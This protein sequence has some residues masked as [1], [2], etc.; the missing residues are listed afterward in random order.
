MVA[1]LD[2]EKAFDR[3]DHHFLQQELQQYGFPQPFLDVVQ[4]IYTN[5]R[6]RILVNGRLSTPF[7]IQRG[8]LQGDPL[9]PLLFVL[10]LEP[11]CQL[12]RQH[13]HYGIKTSNRTHTG[14][15]FADDS[16]L[17]AGN[18]KSLTR[19]LALVAVIL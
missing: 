8:V 9:S 16:Q 1:L 6:S 19:Q 2:F 15:F 13:S 17:Y 10:A 7:R 3:V 14:S 12:L 11:M 18:G 4:V 5:R